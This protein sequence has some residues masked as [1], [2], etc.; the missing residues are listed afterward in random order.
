MVAAE[1]CDALAN[2]L[3][4][5]VL[6]QVAWDRDVNIRFSRNVFAFRVRSVLDGRIASVSFE[7]SSVKI[8]TILSI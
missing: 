6:T 4:N 7:L 1:G 3:R 5:A 8:R 2:K